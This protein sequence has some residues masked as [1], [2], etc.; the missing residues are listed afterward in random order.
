MALIK[1]PECGGK[2]SDTAPA[3]PHCGYLFRPQLYSNPPAEPQEI[4]TDV[5]EMK[6]N[7]TYRYFFIIAG[8]VWVCIGIFFLPL[9]LLGFAFFG[10][11]YLCSDSADCTCP[12][13]GTAGPYQSHTRNYHCPA[14]KKDSVYDPEKHQLKAIR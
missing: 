2:V 11:A 1:C 9:L 4:Y 13:C 14:C 8:I 10:F 5:G 3:C 7:Q 12:F 6:S